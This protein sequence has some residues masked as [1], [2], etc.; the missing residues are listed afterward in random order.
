MDLVALLALKSE[1]RATDLLT[2]EA[3]SIAM[4][5]SWPIFDLEFEFSQ[6]FK[7]SGYLLDHSVQTS[8]MVR[9]KL[10]DQF[11]T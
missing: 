9:A 5:L 10:N 3:I 6:E 11:E 7:P 1:V 8:Y 4:S 2:R